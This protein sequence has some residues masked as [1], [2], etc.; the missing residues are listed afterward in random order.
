MDLVYKSKY[1]K[2]KCM[3]KRINQ[4]L[5]IKMGSSVGVFIGHALYVYSHYNKYPD[6]YRTY[7]A[8]W[9]TSILFYGVILLIV[10]AVC[11]I[12]KVVIQKKI[13]PF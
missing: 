7:S 1:V 3:L 4:L 8:P 5:N 11:F 9:Y 2:G 12:L 10:F 6:L 13:I